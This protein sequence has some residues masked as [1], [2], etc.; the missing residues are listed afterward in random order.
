VTSLDLQAERGKSLDWGKKKASKQKK[1]Q[2]IWNLLKDFISLHRQNE[3]FD[4]PGKFSRE[5]KPYTSLPI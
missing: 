3:S 4:Y 2:N 5:G 1:S